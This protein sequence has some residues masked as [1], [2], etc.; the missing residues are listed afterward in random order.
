ML[1]NTSSFSEFF[2]IVLQRFK[3]LCYTVLSEF[4]NFMLYNT[5]TV[6]EFYV[7]QTCSVS[8]FYVIQYFQCFQ[9]PTSL[10]MC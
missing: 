3:I 5:S 4:Q 9:N 2:V 1:Y 7:I 6:S 8:K 10:W